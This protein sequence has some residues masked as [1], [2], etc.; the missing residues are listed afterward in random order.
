MAGA[1]VAA[2]WSATCRPTAPTPI[3]TAW[4]RAS[5]PGGTRSRWRT[6][7]SARLVS[8]ELIRVS[9]G[10]GIGLGGGDRG[11]TVER[12]GARRPLDDLDQRLVLVSPTGDPIVERPVG[13]RR[14][15]RP[16]RRGPQF[17]GPARAG[18]EP[19]P[20]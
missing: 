18:V 12:P 13:D 5:F 15:V 1:P 14:P 16:V 17:D 4:H 19:Q 10:E 2:S 9:G 7:R 3:T 20:G 11:W 6:S 8:S